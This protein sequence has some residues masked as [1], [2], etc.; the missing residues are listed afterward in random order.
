VVLAGLVAG[1]C[2]RRPAPYQDAF[3]AMDSSVQLTLAGVPEA[4]ARAAAAAARAEVER[5]ESI[6]SDYRPASNVALLNRRATDRPAPE[7]RLLLERAQ[8]VCRAS[9]GAF[10]VSLRPVK[11]LWGFGTGLTMHVPDSSAVRAALHHVGCEVYTLMPDGRLVWNDAEAMLDL[12]GIAQGYVAQCVADT[13]RGRGVRDFLIDISG[14]LVAGGER[15]GGGPWRIGVQHPR[16]PDS[17]LA[18]LRLDAAAVTTSGDYEQF[19]ESGGRRYHHVFD[20]A[21]GRPV[22]NGVVSVTVLSDDAVDADCYTKVIFVL[23][24]E[25]GLELLEARPDLRGLVVSEPRPGRLEVRW[26]DGL[27]PV[28]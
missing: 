16:R 25:R 4:R 23:G 13:L 5:L 11:Q 20:P 28:P 1:A 19:F 14:D 6:L 7:T 15:P 3:L 27:A 10:D 12:G 24:P 21:T 26:S 2:A 18:R 22:D 8:R 17:L 9:G